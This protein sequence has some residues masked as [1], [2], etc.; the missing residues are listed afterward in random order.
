MRLQRSV[1]KRLSEVGDELSRL[2]EGLRILEEQVAYQ[3]SVADQAGV[4][5]VVSSTPLA[6]RERRQAAEDLR[7]LDRQRGE[8]AERIAE[9]IDEQDE[10]LER[11]LLRSPKGRP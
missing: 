9:L 1:E 6:D 8:T 3:G 4:R 11:L 2:R 5:A 10:L 7:R